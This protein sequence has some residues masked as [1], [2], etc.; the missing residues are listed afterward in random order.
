MLCCLNESNV[1]CSRVPPS[2]LARRVEERANALLMPMVLKWIANGFA[3]QTHV[4]VVFRCP[5]MFDHA[6]YFKE[7]QW[8]TEMKHV[9]ALY[10]CFETSYDKILYIYGNLMYIKSINHI[11]V[12][13]PPLHFQKKGSFLKPALRPDKN[14][15]LLNKSFF[16][17]NSFQK[18]DS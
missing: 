7:Y 13:V 10:M 3:Q 11:C 4:G 9:C 17:V 2:S 16:K 1:P 15:W 6:V 14:V 8:W 18:I 12:W 5:Q